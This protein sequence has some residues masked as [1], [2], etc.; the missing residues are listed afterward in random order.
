M[1]KK[2]WKKSKIMKTDKFQTYLKTGL[3]KEDGVYKKSEILNKI[4][5]GL[6]EACSGKI[7]NVKNLDTFL[8]AL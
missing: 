2:I 5:K 8:K 4:K 6:K 7:I 1:G 3:L